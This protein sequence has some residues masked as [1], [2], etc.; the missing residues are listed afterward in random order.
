MLTR[1][2]LVVGGADQP[3][4]TS[5]RDADAPA[6]DTDRAADGP[7][8]RRPDV[9]FTTVPADA[10]LSVWRTEVADSDGVVVVCPPGSADRVDV[11]ELGQLLDGVEAVVVGVV[12]T[13]PARRTRRGQGQDAPAPTVVAAA[14]ARP[15]IARRPVAEDT[16]WTRLTSPVKP[17]PA[18][19]EPAEQ[20]RSA[21][22]APSGSRPNRVKGASRRVPALSRRST[23]VT[24][25]IPPTNE[26]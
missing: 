3:A 17:V 24:V 18:P 6:A 15:S 12:F 2:G 7:A 21:R 25:R 8:A 16:G 4:P 1:R 13:A 10:A 22:P 26:W 5:T 14:P 19:E 11:F 20:A 23:R 9:V